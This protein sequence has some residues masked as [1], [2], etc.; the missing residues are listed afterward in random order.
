MDEFM[1]EDSNPIEIILELPENGNEVEIEIDEEPIEKE[2]PVEIVEVVEP[3]SDKNLN[4]GPLLVK[5]RIPG[6]SIQDFNMDDDKEEEEKK[7]DAKPKQPKDHW[8][9]AFHGL[10]KFIDWANGRYAGVPKHSGKD[11]AGLERAAAYLER[12]YGEVRKAMRIDFDGVLD[13]EKIEKICSE[14]ETGMHNLE[15]QIEKIESSKKKKKANSEQDGFVKNAGV[16]RNVGIVA[17]VPLFIMRC[18]MVIING[19]ISAGH[20]AK[21]I[22]NQLVK[23]YKLDIRE[24]SELEELLINMG[25]SIDIIDRGL[26]VTEDIDATSEDNMELQ[27]QNV[28]G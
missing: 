28:G 5:D 23:K 14:L 4:D 22:Y 12:L 15:T 7:E 13:N 10:H 24:Q 17:T 21:H 18:A 8:D 1:E 25:Y 6:A 26:Y 27:Q 20:D 16:A 3:K 11:I 9:W 2:A 19:S